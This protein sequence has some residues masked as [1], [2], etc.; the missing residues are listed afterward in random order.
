MFVVNPDFSAHHPVEWR[1]SERTYFKK[2]LVMPE[3]QKPFKHTSNFHRLPVQLQAKL[4]RFS[5]TA[6]IKTEERNT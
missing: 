6:A 5:K 1:N 4:K 2:Q 3:F